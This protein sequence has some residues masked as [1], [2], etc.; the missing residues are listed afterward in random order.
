MLD[1]FGEF[2][3]PLIMATIA[4]VVELAKTV[5]KEGLKWPMLL[6]A[7]LGLAL[8]MLY[9]LAQ[10]VPTGL[11]GWLQA[12]V[13]SALLGLAVSGFYDLSKQAGQALLA[14]R[15]K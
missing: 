12:G 9:Q 13:Y 6:S 2:S 8:G 14:T 4:G 11:A 7:G 15:R 1:Q 3:I 10:A 5:Q